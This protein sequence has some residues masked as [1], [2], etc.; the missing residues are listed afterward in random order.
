MPT[1]RLKDCSLDLRIEPL[2]GPLARADRQ[3]AWRV[4]LALLTRPALRD[5]RMP[6]AELR[7]FVRALRA[8]LED[9]PAAELA[10]PRATHL[11]HALAAA[12]EAVFLPCLRHASSEAAAWP[13][14]RDFCR[15]LSSELARLYGFPDAGAGVPGDLW[16]A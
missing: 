9:W 16:G 11:G 4:Y 2:A 7:D 6:E 10:D 8:P 13:A 15:A 14:V 3:C 12:I 1:F 5:E